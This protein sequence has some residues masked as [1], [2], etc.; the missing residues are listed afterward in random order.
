V[1][2]AHA[3]EIPVVSV[4]VPVR[5]GADT[6]AACLDAILATDYPSDRREIFVVDNGSSDGTAALIRARPVR[7]L[8]EPKRGVSHARNQGIA[9]S[10]GEILAFVDADCLVEPQWL[11]ELVRPFEDPEVGA[12]AGDLKHI[13]PSTA[14]ERQSARLLGDWQRFAFTSNPAYPITAN[15]AYRREVLDHIG[16]F[17]PH[18][19]RA[20]DVE[21]G[22]RFQERSRRR[23]AY[24]ERATARHRNRT[25]HL[26]FFR[27]QL[28]W[29][30]GAGLV[31]A[32]FEAMG[33]HPVTPPPGREIAQTV[34]GV[35]T[36][37]LAGIRGH[38]RRDWIEDAW[39]DLL[40]QTAWWIGARAGLRRGA[41]IW[42]AGQ[43]RQSMED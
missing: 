27:Q 36:V 11:A 22:L 10:S 13:A 30:Y 38:G 33:G 39:F 32:K 29:A 25:T 6:I 12:V 9:A 31:G 34:R 37:L 41:R 7:Y 18:M 5:D 16:G 1:A 42:S 20:Q 35:F 2:R 24:A 28:G 43:R 40:R 14:A 15:A 4:I 8:H 21:L 26:G 17:D 3:N 19:T 23:L